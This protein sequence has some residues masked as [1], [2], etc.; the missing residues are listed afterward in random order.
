MWVKR[1]NGGNVLIFAGICNAFP[2]QR[3]MSEVNAVK[4]F[5]GQMN[6]LHVSSTDAFCSN[7]KEKSCPAT[8]R[9]VVT[10]VR[11][12]KSGNR[13]RLVGTTRHIKQN[14]VAVPDATPARDRRIG[15]SDP[16]GT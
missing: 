16:Q 7:G 4:I 11:T 10:N 1:Q 15:L 3:P 12:A 6:P 14:P 13:N 5:D 9:K 2:K 8:S